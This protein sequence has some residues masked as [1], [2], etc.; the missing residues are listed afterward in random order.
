[1][2]K[3]GD[4]LPNE[5]SAEAQAFLD[6]AP[7]PGAVPSSLDA[8]IEYRREVAALYEPRA[9]RA[10]ARWRV[11]VEKTRIGGEPCLVTTPEGGAEGGPIL[12]CYGG[13]FVSGSAYQD[14]ILA[15]PIAAQTSARVVAVE[16]PLSPEHPYPAA[17][18]AAWAVYQ[19]LVAEGGPVR[20]VG[21]SAGG[22]LA[23]AL[24]HRIRAEGA[25]PPTA[26]ALLS[27]WCD[28][29]NHGDSFSAPRDPTLDVAW[30]DVASRAY[31]GDRDAAD[32]GPSPL[33]GAFDAG[34]PPM[35]ITT[36]TRDLLLS[37]ATRLA[38]AQRAA[39][40]PVELHLWDGMW[41]VFEFY[42]ELPEAAASIAEIAAFLQRQRR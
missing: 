42:D 8:L 20:L 41:H 10:I 31:L 22:N 13:G 17:L 29:A 39:G 36:G 27:P 26:A 4:R 33:Y 37:H 16:Y 19:A 34:D 2:L 6:S 21:E 28:L 24:L 32:P 5:M 18:D 30:I 11:Q 38:R 14:Q 12:Y 23:L 15:A 9:E 7:P 35:L 25:T 3:P 1:M 40:A